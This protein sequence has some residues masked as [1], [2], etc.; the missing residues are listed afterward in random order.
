MMRN[1]QKERLAAGAMLV[2]ALVASACASAPAV[3]SRPAAFPG[4]PAQ[5]WAAT[6]DA[7]LDLAI[8]DVLE[9]A[10]SLR[11]SPYQFGGATPQ[12]GFDCSGF[13]RYVFARGQLDV[14]RTV[15]EQYRAGRQVARSHIGTGDLVF[16]STTGPG[17][18]HVGIVVDPVERT[19]V[20][21]PG[22]GSVV[23]V[24]R[25]DT[26]YWNS[27]M[28]GARRLPLPAPPTSSSASVMAQ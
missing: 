24:E 6:R 7:G 22:T 18:T 11:G 12:S 15:A 2:L 10:V 26:P 17:A 16:F 4:A 13:V 25:F 23:R 8:R 21:A 20:H 27:R 28:L 14:P 1:S 3:G 5:T 19:F 9:T